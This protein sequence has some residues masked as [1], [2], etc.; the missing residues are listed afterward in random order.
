MSVFYLVV[1]LILSV[2]SYGKEYVYG[3]ILVLPSHLYG[4]VVSKSHQKT[5]II[6]TKNGYP[7]VIDEF[8]SATGLRFG[9]KIKKGDMKTPSGVYFP[10]SFKPDNQLPPY[11]GSGAF[12]LNYPNAL[13]RYI[14]RRDGDGIWIHGYGKKELLF[15]SSRGCIILKNDDLIRL[16]KYI[17]IGKTPVV[18]QEKFVKLHLNEFKNL[19]KMS[20]EFIEKWKDALIQLYK[21]DDT[22]LYGL[23]ARDFNSSVGSRYDQINNYKK[24]IYR[25]GNNPPFIILLNKTIVIDERKNGKRYI[26]ARFQMGFLSG[27]EL[28]RVK[29]VLYIRVNG[30]RLEIISEE[31]F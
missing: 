18:I 24:A 23:Y 3:N 27:D 22:A 5:L 19:R 26:V 30:K 2:Y 13:D 8:I 7:T 20:E 1:F 29:K 16:S 6:Q 10:V 12:P 4:V 25:K 31:N 15:F 17:K 14:L 11:Y 21:G 28:K 9:D